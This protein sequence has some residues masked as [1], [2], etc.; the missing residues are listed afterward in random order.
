MQNP[1]NGSSLWAEQAQAIEDSW[2]SSP[3]WAG[4]IRQHSTLDVVRLRGSFQT[5]QSLARRGAERLWQLLHDQPYVAALGAIS[6]GQAVQQVKAGLQ[7]IY[8]SGWQIAADAN[9]AGQVYPDQGLYPWDSIP[10]LVRRINQALLRADQ[11]QHL[12]GAA[13]TDWLAPIIADAESG[14][15]GPLNVFELVKSMIEAGAAGIHLE[16]QL[17][18]EKKCGHM[19]GKV[20]IPTAWAVRNLGA[21]RLAADV[22]DVP[23]IIIART[24]ANSANLLTSDADPYDR[25]HMTGERT[26]EGFFRLR[27]GIDSAVSRGLAYAP[28]ADMLWCETAHPDLREAEFFARAIHQRHPNKLLAYNCSPSFNW[29]RDLGDADLAEF[30][31]RL[32]EFGYRFQ[33][34]TLAGFHSLNHSMFDLAHGY[35]RQG[36]LAYS[37]LQEAEFASEPQGYTA[38]RHQREAAAGYFDEVARIIGGGQSSTTALPGS[39]EEE[40]FVVAPAAS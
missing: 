17:A 31:L 2:R 36:M 23:T 34:I 12:E 25:P 35:R 39:T 27:S 38:V 4:V 24:D 40:Q 18:S 6:G 26:A 29:R 1:G 37:R 15:G 20:L 7:A 28:Y 5:E 21:A 9:S 19:G 33:F 30:H 14:F 10:T 13:D 3:R 16:D 11:I 22:M 32:A 8:V